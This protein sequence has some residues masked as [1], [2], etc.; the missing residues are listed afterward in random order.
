MGR[1]GAA[2]RGTSGASAPGA[3]RDAEDRASNAEVTRLMTA[4]EVAHRWQVPKAHVYRLTRR[5]EIPTV[6][7][8]RYV[9]Y[10]VESIEAWELAQEGGS[11]A[12]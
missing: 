5:G 2:S 11:N 1:S 7:L 3:L 9:R 8:G 6:K 10:R 12:G 4:D